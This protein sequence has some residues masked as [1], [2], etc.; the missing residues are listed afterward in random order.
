MTTSPYAAARLLFFASACC[1]NAGALAGSTVPQYGYSGREPDASGLDYYRARYYDPV[2]G[3]FLQRD[4]IGLGGGIA[5][6][7]YA[8]GEPVGA[9]DP[10]GTDPRQALNSADQTYWDKMVGLAESGS[11][12]ARNDPVLQGYNKYGALLIPAAV[13]SVGIGL[14]GEIGMLSL[15]VTGTLYNLALYYQEAYPAIYRTLMAGGGSA[16]FGGSNVLAKGG[17]AGDA[18]L[19][20]AVSFLTGGAL[21]WI[22][23]AVR[24]DIGT[25]GLA[26][27]RTAVWSAHGFYAPEVMALLKDTPAPT[28]DLFDIALTPGFGGFRLT[29]PEIG[30]PFP[31]VDGPTGLG[32]LDVAVR[33]TLPFT[34][35]MAPEARR[36]LPSYQDLMRILLGPPGGLY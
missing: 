21:G 33:N 34:M 1:L 35:V 10:N 17:S 5:D 8:G 36:N 32:P 7:A 30:P 15:P 12:A 26:A 18:G 20:A 2:L 29:F 6:Y 3:R 24:A 11:A 4:P 14:S 13:S 22:A 28:P 19:A 23:P 31:G 9:S 25:W 16:V 27:V